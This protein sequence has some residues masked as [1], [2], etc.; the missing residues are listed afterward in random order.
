MEKRRGEPTRSGGDVHGNGTSNRDFGMRPG[1]L[2]VQFAAEHARCDHGDAGV[3]PQPGVLIGDAR[4]VD[5]DAVPSP[6]SSVGFS[7]LEVAPLEKLRE[8]PE[9]RSMAAC[10]VDP[11][12]ARFG[13]GR[14]TRRKLARFSRHVKAGAASAAA[15]TSSAATRRWSCR[16]ESPQLASRVAARQSRGR[17]QGAVM[18]HRMC[19][20]NFGP[21]GWRP[22]RAGR[23]AA[24]RP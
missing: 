8:R 21:S 17:P 10:H 9:G 15:S 13:W 19:A 6:T 3:A 2:P 18:W 23:Q 22:S 14:A 1:L 7:N 12:A 24:A 5:D 16:R 11:P 20:R 4:A